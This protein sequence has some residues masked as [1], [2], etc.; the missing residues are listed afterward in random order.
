LQITAPISPGS[1]GSP[2]LDSSGKVIGIATAEMRDGQSVNFAVPAELAA[3]ML[4]GQKSTSPLPLETL[5]RFNALT[6]DAAESAVSESAEYQQVTRALLKATAAAAGASIGLNEHADWAKVLN[7]AK[8]LVAKYPSSG[9]AHAELGEVYES[10]GLTDDA[11]EAYQRAVKLNP[12]Q[13]LTWNTLGLIYKKRNEFTQADFAFQQA[14]AFE[15]NTVQSRPSGKRSTPLAF[16]GDIYKSAGN[17]EAAEK[18]YLQAIQEEPNDLGALMSLHGLAATYLS[19][20]NEKA[21][22]DIAYQIV[23]RNPNHKTPQAEAWE[24]L[25]SWYCDH[26]RDDDCDRCYRNAQGLG[27]QR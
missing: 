24:Y 13:P 25:S 9:V 11:I 17:N 22:L 16:L 20:G 21:A 18:C 3:A 5:A 1:S 7:A 2:V 15:T 12:D 4:H 10:M 23:L 26:H 27:L 14:I 19:R 8:A 6:N